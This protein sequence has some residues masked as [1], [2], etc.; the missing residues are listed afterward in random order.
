[1]K[2]RVTVTLKSGILDPEPLTERAGRDIAAHDLQRNDF[3]LANQLLAHVEPTDKMRRHADVVEVLEHVLRDPIVEDTLALDHLMLF[4]IERGG[5]ILEVLDQ[6]TGLRTF[7]QDLCLAF[8]NA[9]PTAHGDV[10][11]FVEI[12][13]FG[14]LRLT[15]ITTHSGAAVNGLEPVETEQEPSL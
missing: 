14:V 2:A 4:R 11:C 1:M 15:R 10:P 6:G 9:T 7:V 13:E 5:V 3:D 8:I 12:H